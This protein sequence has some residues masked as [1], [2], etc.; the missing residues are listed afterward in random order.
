MQTGY[1]I[2]ATAHGALIL[3]ALIGGKFTSEPLDFEVQT[4]SIVSSSEFE[5]LTG[6]S[7]GP[8]AAGVVDAPSAPELTQP[9]G[10]T[11]SDA[12]ERTTSADATPETATPEIANPQAPAESLPARPAPLPS[13]S[14][15]AVADPPPQ[16][17]APDSTQ[18][19]LVLPAGERQV[20]RE[21]D[22]VAPRPV[23]QPSP[24]TAVSE[25]PLQPERAPTRSVRPRP[26]PPRA[27]SPAP[28]NTSQATEADTAQTPTETAP[29]PPPPAPGP[30]EQAQPEQTATTAP[31][32]SVRPRTRPQRPATPP[33]PAPATNPDAVNS[34]L[35][36]ALSQSDTAPTS[37][38]GGTANTNPLTQGERS[39]F[40]VAVERCWTIDEGSRAS[41]VT[42]IVRMSM[43]PN[44]TVVASSL[45]LVNSEGGDASAVETAYQ[46]VRRAILRC[47]HGGYD[48]PRDKYDQWQ[49]IE[50]K[51]NR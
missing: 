1:V 17:S 19:T 34:A 3:W 9:E 13:P 29:P 38:N 42:V 46:A 50:M 24:E 41:E 2:S 43:E 26:R 6:Q 16:Q 39:A 7:G 28:A 22:R 4:V 35:A 27:T 18:T 49:T 25:R 32:R 30:T 14:R 31:T 47:Q 15:P 33:T 10:A 11:Q 40:R 45:E 5:A 12:P 48:L 37:G 23:A 44:G 36:E 51:F 8:A 20:S 21:I